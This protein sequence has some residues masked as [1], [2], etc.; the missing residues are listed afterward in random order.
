M[1]RS[2][3]KCVAFSAL[4]LIHFLPRSALY[5]SFKMWCL[6][7]VCCL[8]SLLYYYPHTQSTKCV[9]VCVH[10]LICNDSLFKQISIPCIYKSYI[11]N[12]TL[13]NCIGPSAF[14]MHR[15]ENNNREKKLH[16]SGKSNIKSCNV[17]SLKPTRRAFDR[18]TDRHTLPLWFPLV[19]V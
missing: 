7:C 12:S 8:A 17:N 6:V 14:S 19:F 1:A 18:P 4:L 9:C 11:H 15:L 5:E 13:F 10:L 3:V 2:F 16:R